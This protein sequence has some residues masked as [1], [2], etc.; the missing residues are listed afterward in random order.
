MFVFVFGDFVLVLV[1]VYVLCVWCVNLCF[2]LWLEE[3]KLFHGDLLPPL[4]FTVHNRWRMIRLLNLYA[5]NRQGLK[6]KNQINRCLYL[7]IRFI[8]L[9]S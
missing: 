5:K 1:C 6:R 4:P 9:P 7:L 2:E 3:F 8:L